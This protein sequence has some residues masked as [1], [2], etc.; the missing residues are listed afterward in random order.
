MSDKTPEAKARQITDNQMEWLRLII[1]SLS[2]EP[3][4]LELN[5]FDRKGGLAGSMKCLGT[6]TKKVCMR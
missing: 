5:L 1:S 6:V 4:D 3:D 2:I